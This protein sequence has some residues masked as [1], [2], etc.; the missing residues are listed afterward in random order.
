MIE[1]RNTIIEQKIR[2]IS[3]F[4]S[5]LYVVLYVMFVFLL[6]TLQSRCNGGHYEGDTLNGKKHGKGVY[7]WADGDR[8]EGDFVDDKRMGKGVYIWSNGNRYEG[9][10]VHGEFHG[11][12]TLY[13]KDGSKRT[14]TWR[15]DE[16]VSK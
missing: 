1:I 13:Y 6:I 2:N 11:Q 3:S 15:N 9:D 5:F 7:T 14:G 10:F 16:Y 12:G 4:K 8:Y